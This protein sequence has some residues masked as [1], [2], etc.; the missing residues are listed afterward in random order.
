M[1][2]LKVRKI[3][4][5][6]RA[7]RRLGLCV[8][9]SASAYNRGHARSESILNGPLMLGAA[10]LND[11]VEESGDRL[12]FIATVFEHDSGHS[13]DVRD[14]GNGCALTDLTGVKLCRHC[15]PAR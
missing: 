8:C 6:P 7:P 5:P 3:A 13:D 10:I 15:T 2:Q 11:V 14:G 1:R 4:L 12:V 9:V